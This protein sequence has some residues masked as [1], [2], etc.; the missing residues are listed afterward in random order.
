[1]QSDYRAR[2]GVRPHHEPVCAHGRRLPGR[3]FLCLACR[4]QVLICSHCDRGHVYCAKGCAQQARRRSLREAGHRYQA[5]RRGRIKHA[6]RAR[7]YRARKNTVTHQGSPPDRTEA[8]LAET[9]ATI[10]MEEAT[11]SKSDRQR[12][13]CDCCG[14]PCPDLVRRDFLQRC[15][16]PWNNRRGPRRDHSP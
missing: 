8:L 2:E 10:T 12:W 3:L 5:S 13:H 15:R 9:P 7:R 4:A 1:M 11:T 6:E 14:Q 16:D